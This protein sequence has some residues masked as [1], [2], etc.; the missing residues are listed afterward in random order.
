MDNLVYDYDSGNKLTKVTDGGNDTY[1]FKDGNT[2]GDDYVYDANGNLTK[3]RNK[4]I[5]SIVYNH[6]NLP[7]QITINGGGNNGTISYIYDATGIKIAKQVSTGTSTEYCGNYIYENGNLQ[8]FSH[9]EGYVNAAGNDYEYVYQCKDHLGNIRLSYADADGNGSIDPNNEIIEENNYYPFGLE[10]KGYNN[11]VNGT[12]NNYQT[13]QGQENEE[14]LGKNTYA[15]QWRDYDPAIG[16]FNK[17]DRYAEKYYDQSPYHFSGNNP[18]YFREVAGDSIDVSGIVDYD[19]NNGT[20]ILDQVKTDLT[21]ATGL[22]FEVKNG[23]LVYTKDEDG[24]A[25]IA[26]DGD[27]NQLG[28]SEARGFLTHSL[29]DDKNTAFAT[30]STTGKSFVGDSAGNP[31]VGGDHIFLHLV[32]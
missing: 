11:V 20:N 10:H 23:K 21:T 32:K 25:V 14:E 17:I 1:G 19:K 12:E 16:R 7:T 31:L 5:T 24:N 4:H 6:L 29:D 27:G 8:F 15:F 3:D 30:I 18:I 22:S 2:S 9:P 26:T 28:S 13:Y